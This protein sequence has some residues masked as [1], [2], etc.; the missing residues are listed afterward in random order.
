MC[1]VCAAVEGT[2]THDGRLLL[3]DVKMGEDQQHINTL[4]SMKTK[5]SAKKTVNLSA[6]RR[7]TVN[8]RKA[9]SN[10]N[11]GRK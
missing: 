6:N 10:N 11:N 5:T 8:K 9:H 2:R 1:C 7:Q 4:R 3:F